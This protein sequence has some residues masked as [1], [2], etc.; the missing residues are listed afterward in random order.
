MHQMTWLSGLTIIGCNIDS[1]ATLLCN[2]FCSYVLMY[3]N[4]PITPVYVCMLADYNIIDFI[5]A[6]TSSKILRYVVCFYRDGGAN[7]FYF[8]VLIPLTYKCNYSQGGDTPI[9]SVL[10]SS[11]SVKMKVK[12]QPPKIA[13]GQKS[14]C[15]LAEQESISHLSRVRIPNFIV[16]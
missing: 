4:R 10:Q 5:S 16:G 7:L 13:D 2:V 1:V 14:N 11:S 15:L 12:G 3:I 9:Y 6:E 8:K